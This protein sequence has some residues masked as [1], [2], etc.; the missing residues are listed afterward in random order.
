MEKICPRCKYP[1]EGIYECEYCGLVFAQNNK[2]QITEKSSLPNIIFSLIA[3]IGFLGLVY[4]WYQ[5]ESAKKMAELEEI[6]KLKIGEQNKTEK[7]QQ[8]KII[9]KQQNTEKDKK[10]AVIPAKKTQK[11]IPLATTSEQQ[12]IETE[13]KKAVSP[14]NKTQKTTSSFISKV[15]CRRFNIN[16]VL[17]GKELKFWLG[18]D[19]PND[20]IVMAKG[21][22]S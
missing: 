19:L 4:F 14:V 8:E 18:T 6:R 15:F 16:T 5:Y 17:M 7:Q 2:T 12:N 21:M 22:V 9:S 3:F 13:K 20:T 11:T 10:K 1:Q